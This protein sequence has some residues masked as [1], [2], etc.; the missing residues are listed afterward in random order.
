MEPDRNTALLEHTRGALAGFATLDLS[1]L[2]ADGALVLL[3]TVG[4]SLRLGLPLPRELIRRLESSLAEE[5]V[6]AAL[7]C[8]ANSIKDWALPRRHDPDVEDHELEWV[9]R[10]RDEV[11]S[12]LVAAR[13]LLLPRG[14]LVDAS[15]AAERLRLALSQH[16][17][18]CGRGVTRTDAELMLGDRIGLLEETPWL[19]TIA[20][21][22]EPSDEAGEV[23]PDLRGH[24]FP[25]VSTLHRYVRRGELKAWVEDAAARSQEVAEELREMIDGSRRTDVHFIALR[26]NQL[27]PGPVVLEPPGPAMLHAAAQEADL[28][29]EPS[30]TYELGSLDPVDAVAA[31]Q[32]S[33]TALVLE[34][35]EGETPLREVRLGDA[36]ATAPAQ[37]HTW[38]AFK[39]RDRARSDEVFAICVV[40]SAGREFS[41]SI[42]IAPSPT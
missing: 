27:N 36:R 16:D 39:A 37:G 13:R 33:T 15:A 41:V 35:F 32:I 5:R 1:G 34:V 40:D 25:S 2:E 7:D 8:L 18:G 23:L 26:W 24:A 17:L 28:P 22:P 4:D 12:A 42:T 29:P 20:W 3:V 10:R 9:V 31:L 38:T 11:E 19:D 6:L 30:R 21:A 14:I